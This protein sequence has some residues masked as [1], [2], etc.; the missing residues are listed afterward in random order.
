M[1]DDE[2]PPAR[3]DQEYLDPV[4]RQHPFMRRQLELGPDM[5]RLSRWGD[6]H[7][8]LLGG[9]WWDNTATPEGMTM[10]LG[11]VGDVAAVAAQ[12][13]RL[14]AHPEHLRV[15]AQRHPLRELRRLQETI[16]DD[17]AARWQ[18]LWDSG[19]CASEEEFWRR[20]R[21]GPLVV[22]VGV[23]QEINKVGVGV[24]PRDRAFAAA[25]LDRYGT[26]RVHVH[27][28]RLEEMWF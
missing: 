6:D 19:E 13:R 9:L 24:A 14:L 26:D 27:W 10:C 22:G 7:P 5:T 8:D 2:A 12:V 3:E 15:I 16:S 18:A 21:A 1:N 4:L 23:E 17:E 20:M 11:V 25:L 28:D